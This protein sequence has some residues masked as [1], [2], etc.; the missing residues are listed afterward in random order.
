MKMG[1]RGMLVAQRLSKV[2]KHQLHAQRLTHLCPRATSAAA[3]AHAARIF[4]PQVR[5]ASTPGTHE[6]PKACLLVI[7][8]EV[9]SGS[10]AD[11]N[12]PWLARLL[13]SRGV[14]LI[15]VEYIPDDVGDIMQSAINLRK[16]VGPS[17]FVFTSGG[18]GPTH[19]DVTYE[20]L[21]KA[22]GAQLELHGPT[23]ERMRESYAR[24]GM[25]LNE[26]RLRMATLPTP[27]EVLFSEGTWVPLVNL[28]NVY[29]LPGIPKLFQTMISSH[30]S[31][32][33]G[34]HAFEERSLFSVQG[35]SF[36]S[37]R[38]SRV[39]AAN[40]KVA[41][42]SYPNTNEKTE[43]TWKVRVVVRG[44]EGESLQ[45]AV[46]SLREHIPELQTQEPSTA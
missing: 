23:V 7:G 14:D 21:A 29:I 15:R 12:T 9:L 44:R 2:V 3:H 41:I 1:S 27:S 30:Q 28:N 20:A 4:R 8:D 6:S 31:R 5:C 42:G 45:A 37:E 16:R 24:R 13:Y 22:F 36:I 32:F 40:P 11:A 35:E 33:T 39:A 46:K 19:D 18:I 34:M 26:A 10:I 38:I 17:G 25:E 43:G